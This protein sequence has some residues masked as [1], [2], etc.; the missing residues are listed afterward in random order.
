MKNK[1][2]LLVTSVVLIIFIGAGFFL[3]SS[4][5][6]SLRLS[7]HS[8][9]APL[10][11]TVTGP[12]TLLSNK[13]NAWNGWTGCG[14]NIDWG[15]GTSGELGCATAF[16]H[17]YKNGGTFL[18]KAS[19]F[20]ASPVDSPITDWTGSAEVHVEGVLTAAATSIQ[21][22]ISGSC[23]PWDGPALNIS[24]NDNGGVFKAQLYAKGLELFKTGKP[25]VINNTMDST[26]GTGQASFCPSDTNCLPYLPGQVHID[27]PSGV[28]KPNTPIRLD[29]V[30]NGAV[31]PVEAYWDSVAVQPCG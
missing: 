25:V 9:E 1:I 29:I 20:H 13:D 24:M 26:D 23:A 8:G 10:M 14:F 3:R 18:V 28:I 11:V 21:A 16:T 7:A 15:D 4:K 2:I 30:I 6:G 17:I 22:T 31:I 5:T 27:N 12:V 19:T